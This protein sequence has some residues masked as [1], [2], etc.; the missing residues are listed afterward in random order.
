MPRFV[1][2]IKL[3]LGKNRSIDRVARAQLRVAFSDDLLKFRDG[4]EI[5]GAAG[6]TLYIDQT[7]Q[8]KAEAFDTTNFDLDGVRSKLFI[9]TTSYDLPK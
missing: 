2:K 1:G 5:F 9:V 7:L 4:F 3:D 6:G 8:A